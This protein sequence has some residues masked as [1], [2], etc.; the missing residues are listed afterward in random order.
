MA[1]FP[2]QA[3][4]APALV[5]QTDLFRPHNDPD[6]HWDL[7]CV[8]ALAKLGR[9]H[10]RGILIDSPPG[11][12]V[13]MHKSDP[14]VGAVAQLS[15]LT[16]ISAPIAVGSAT[17]LSQ[18]GDFAPRPAPSGVAFLLD[19]LR[20]T[21]QGVY[22]TAVGS[23]RD[24]AEALVRDPDLFAQRCRGIYLN[25]GSGSPDPAAVKALEWNAKLDPLAFAEIFRA[26]CPLFW[27]PDL[28]DEAGAG[29]LEPREYATHYR[30]LQREIL[31]HLPAPFRAYFGWMF[32]R[33]NTCNWLDALQMDFEPLL[34]TK[35]QEHRFMYSTAG[36][37]DV[38]GLGVTVEGTLAPKVEPRQDWVYRF[39]PVD[40]TCSPAGV[41]TWRPARGPT[42]R[43]I[44]HVLN[45]G[46]YT[47][48]MT[49]AM[50]QL[51]QAMAA[52]CGP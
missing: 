17:M 3:G 30:F 8:F 27:M 49:S 50:R 51:L 23:A 20:Q 32:T 34:A 12:P 13:L 42:N 44:F 31:P 19:T 28:Q 22:I 18:R 43:H 11:P 40:V 46:A 15:H 21:P 25:A 48:A 5:H 33:Q 16:G 7:A 36:F 14:D 1:H 47:V 41:T 9:A 4:I 29:D 26:P 2:P 52:A 39:E 10:L 35:E 38:A 45:T 37:F 6:D 24:I